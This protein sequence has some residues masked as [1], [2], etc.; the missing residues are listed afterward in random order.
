MYNRFSEPISR[1]KLKYAIVYG[2]N[3]MPEAEVR[4]MVEVAFGDRPF[5]Y[6]ID[7]DGYGVSVT[8]DGPA[9]YRK[10][11]ALQSL[12]VGWNLWVLWRSREN[13]VRPSLVE[14]AMDKHWCLYR[15]DGTRVCNLYSCMEKMLR[16][17]DLSL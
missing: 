10:Q 11:E 2:C 8:S 6:W 12:L 4:S 1:K 5:T 16:N 7:R 15:D 3:R 13:D 9:D 14:L 17:V